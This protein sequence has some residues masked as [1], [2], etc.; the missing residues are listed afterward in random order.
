M[1]RVFCLLLI[2]ALLLVPSACGS[3]DR[4]QTDDVAAPALTAT[5]QPERSVQQVV[6][7]ADT[8]ER[9]R[10]L[11]ETY[12]ANGDSAGVYLA[13]K[14]L[15]DLD[16]ADTQACK[17]AVSAL[18]TTISDD[19]EEIESLLW[20]CVQASPESADELI[21]WAYE[22]E[23]TFSYDVPFVPDYESEAEINLEGSTPGNLMNRT[24]YTEQVCP[25]KASGR[26]AC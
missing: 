8:A 25:A 13:A 15:I 23:Q 7:A 22:Q 6:A 1:K 2:L 20:Q 17:D 21:R 12:R 10:A 16:P 11:V 19:C 18:L 5:E 4:A 3:A 14:K 26:A 24:L 9:A